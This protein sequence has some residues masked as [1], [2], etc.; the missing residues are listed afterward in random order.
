MNKK[1]TFLGD[2]ITCGNYLDEEVR[3]VTLVKK[4]FPWAEFHNH[5]V[6][7][8]RIGDYI[9][10]DPRRIGP[11][12]VERYSGM[13]DDMDI[14]VVFGGSNDFGIGNEPLGSKEDYTTQTFYGALN[15]LLTGLKKKY[16]HAII[17]YM[18]PIHRRNEMEPNVFTGAA[19]REYIEAIRD[20]VK[21]HGIRLLDLYE[22]K[23]LQPNETYYENLIRQDGIHP[24][25][26][27]HRLIAEELIAYLENECNIF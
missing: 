16:E 21:A 4:H 15:V 24:N 14:V 17:I 8:S 2:S 19:F 27:G 10:V 11:S 6:S 1:I 9:G 18:T 13:P 20:R 25:E 5:S 26:E 7:G 23:S 12:F 22:A 3:Y